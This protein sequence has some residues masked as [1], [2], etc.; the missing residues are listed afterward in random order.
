MHVPEDDGIDVDRHGVAG[1]RLL[2]IELRG[3]DALVDDGGDAVDD[4]DDEEQAGTLDARQLAG[5]QDDEALPVVGH[6]QRQS[7]QHR[8]NAEADAD[9]R[10]VRQ[11]CERGQAGENDDDQQSDGIHGV[12]SRIHKIYMA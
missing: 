7:G 10:K 5:A 3:L 4:R 8:K 9:G 11:P 12:A 1:E 2:G 6:L